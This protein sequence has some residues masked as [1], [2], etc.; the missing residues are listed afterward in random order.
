MNI[1]VHVGSSFNYEYSWS[2]ARVPDIEKTTRVETVRVADMWSASLSLKSFYI[3]QNSH[4]HLSS[5][6]I[7]NQKHLRW[8][9]HDKLWKSLIRLLCTTCSFDMQGCHFFFWFI[10]RPHIKSIVSAHIRTI[11]SLWNLLQLSIGLKK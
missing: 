6:C 5:K 3:S 9:K 2:G 4:V 10:S 11:F 1:H 7:S 8:M